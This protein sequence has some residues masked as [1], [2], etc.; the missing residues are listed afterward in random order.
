[1]A[2]GIK[3]VKINSFFNFLGRKE[4]SRLPEDVEVDVRELTPDQLRML[5]AGRA[6]TTT[7]VKV[8]VTVFTS[9]SFR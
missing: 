8:S 6:D 5:K 1:M 9:P 3:I 4:E 2:K 7:P